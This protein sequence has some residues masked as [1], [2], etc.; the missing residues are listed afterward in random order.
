MTCSD[1]KPRFSYAERF[2][3]R[4]NKMKKIILKYNKPLGKILDVG[5]GDGFATVRLMSDLTCVYGFEKD[6][7]EA[8]KA[9][10][11]FECK[12]CNCEKERFPF[13]DNFFDVVHAGEIIEHL[14]D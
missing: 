10:K 14:L 6:Q 12:Q 1:L 13:D 8:E 3:K 5:C 4:F 11:L 7:K 2:E 9:N